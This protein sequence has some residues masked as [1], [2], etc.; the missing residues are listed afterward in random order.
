MIKKL[1]KSIRQYKLPSILSPVFV[2]LE[3]VMEVLIPYYMADLLDKGVNAGNMPEIYKYGI[4]LVVFAILS[5][6]FGALAG[7]ASARAASGFAANLRHD[8]FYKVQTFSFLNIDKFSTSSLVT[9]MTTDVT[10]VQMAYMMLIRIAVRSPLM[11]VFSLIMAFSKNATISLIFLA[12][13]PV[14]GIGLFI[15][16]KKAMPVFESVFTTYDDLNTVVQEDVR[17]IRVVKS[18]VREDEENKKFGKVS[19]KIY[20][21]FSRAEKLV[22]WNTPLMQFCIYVCMLFASWIGAKLIVSNQMTT[23]ELMSIITYIMQMLMSLMMLAMIFVMLTMSAASAKRIIE[24]LDEEPD[25]KNPDNPETEVLNGDIDFND[26]S[27]SYAKN[28]D[29]YCLY[30]VDIHIKSGQTIG[31]I[32]GTGSSKSTLVSLI[33]RLY[34]ATDGSVMLGG[35]DVKSYDIKVLRDAVSMVLQKNELFSGTIKENLRWGDENATDEDIKRV[36]AEACADE[37][38]ETL[39][40][41]YDTYIEQGGTNVSGGQK[42]RLCI[43]R[44]LLKKPKVLIL[45]DSTSAVDT[46][47]DSMIRKAFREEIPDTTKLIIAQRISSVMDA[48]KILVLDGGRVSA[49]GPH[50]EL[51]KT[52]E[53]YKEVYESQMKGG[54]F[55]EA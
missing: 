54:D 29:K 36:C 11:L 15:I 50:E 2:A 12:V 31:I 21:L 53:I 38:I 47:T 3:V 20:K 39:P 55:D 18:F 34:D 37:F 6:V 48:D 45:D 23:G 52:S 44:A 14:L 19:E 10:N 1:M 26:V 35:K 41:K 13:I 27:F 24:V 28:K 22:A 25:I 43:A 4:M 42:Q 30:D 5:L 46:H 49:F 8:M 33:A 16:I 9:R 17:G 32:G 51:M 40:E 7:G